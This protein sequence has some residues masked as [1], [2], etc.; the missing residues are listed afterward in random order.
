MRLVGNP[1]P[2][3]GL[4]LAGPL[5]D[6][7]VLGLLTCLGWVL[8]AQLLV[9]VAVETV[10]QV[11]LLRLDRLPGAGAAPRTGEAR[12]GSGGDLG[13]W[14][15]R[16]PGTFAGQQHLARGLVQLI[17][18]AALGLSATTAA[19]TT[20]TPQAA[21]AVLTDSPARP[22]PESRGRSATPPGSPREGP[23]HAGD[24]VTPRKAALDATGVT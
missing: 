22:A 24:A 4:H 5:T 17:V 15:A 20:G 3:G 18:T 14:M 12:R 21:A 2:E 19:A 6:S 23:R 8:W 11:R 16:V 9:C 13:G 10:A 7:A 1:Y